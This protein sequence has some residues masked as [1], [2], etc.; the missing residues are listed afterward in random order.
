MILSK[1]AL[2]DAIPGLEIETNDVK[3]TH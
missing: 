2:A 3:A 1:D